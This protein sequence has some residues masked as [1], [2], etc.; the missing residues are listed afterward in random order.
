MARLKDRAA[1]QTSHYR[2]CLQVLVFYAIY[3][4]LYEQKKVFLEIITDKVHIYGSRKHLYHHS[5][6]K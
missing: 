1:V 2:Q 3:R 4:A 5:K 6:G